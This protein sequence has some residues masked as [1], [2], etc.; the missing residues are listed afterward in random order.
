[1]EAKPFDFDLVS[2]LTSYLFICFQFIVKRSRF[3]VYPQDLSVSKLV[4]LFVPLRK[5]PKGQKGQK[6][7]RSK[8]QKGQK[9]SK[10]LKV[11]R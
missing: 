2:D 7:R 5:G 10:G 3:T 6:G 9:R 4:S 1:M 11:K 8:G